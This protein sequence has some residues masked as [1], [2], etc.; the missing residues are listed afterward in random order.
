MGLADLLKPVEQ[1]VMK[2]VT[3][4]IRSDVADSWPMTGYSSPIRVMEGLPTI[5]PLQWPC[6]LVFELVGP[7]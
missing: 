7:E 1:R 6:S 3:C 2:Q 4:I 5:R